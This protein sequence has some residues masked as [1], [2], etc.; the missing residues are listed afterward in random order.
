MS[1]EPD[2]QGLFSSSFLTLGIR[3]RVWGVAFRISAP[4]GVISLQGQKMPRLYATRR[5]IALL[6]HTGSV[7]CWGMAHYGGAAVI[8]NSPTERRLLATEP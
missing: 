5:A 4:V 7:W 8:E 3:V 1:S 2:A 6:E